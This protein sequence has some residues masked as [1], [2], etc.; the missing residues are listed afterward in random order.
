MTF[1]RDMINHAG[2]RAEHEV[3]EKSTPSLA[4]RGRQGA[5]TQDSVNQG[6]ECGICAC[7]V[8]CHIVPPI[9]HQHIERLQRLDVMPPERR[10]EYSVSR[11][12]LGRMRRGQCIA[13]PWIAL[14]VGPA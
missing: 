1:P 5:D 9:V 4:R 6:I 14:E 2:A 3:L 12:H 11:S 10:Y 7:A 8:A 13:K